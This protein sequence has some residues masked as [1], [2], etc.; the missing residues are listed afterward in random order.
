M[1]G[2]KRG[3]E[4]PLF[5]NTND[6]IAD[7]PDEDAEVR[8]TSLPTPTTP[9]FDSK[10]AKDTDV[11]SSDIVARLNVDING[12]VPPYDAFKAEGRPRLAFYHP[13]FP[14]V[15]GLL[16]EAARVFLAAADSEFENGYEDPEIHNICHN[17]LMR[18]LEVQDLY[19]SFGP[20]ALLGPAGAGKSSLLNALLNETG[21]A[22]E[23]DGAQ[24]GTNLVHEY[25][26]ASPRQESKYQV[27]VPFYDESQIRNMVDSHC[28]HIFEYLKG[29]DEEGM[30]DDEMDAL[31]DQ[32]S[33]AL[34][35]FTVLLCDQ[36]DFKS[37]DAAKEYFEFRRKD[38]I[39]DV[40]EHL[41]EYIEVFKDTRTL[42]DGK[43][44]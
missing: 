29:G 23:S 20:I 1:A 10:R 33:A 24:R 38:P 36:A 40:V 8:R 32:C 39:G 3:A 34:G 6:D 14:E 9:S 11:D 25:A 26:G 15:E 44:S 37:K 13:D 35:F 19:P 42:V 16:L 12:K 18:L 2:V 4:S 43:S 27:V 17:D 21:V 31:E 7:A 5:V 41:T 30:E 28:K 22:I